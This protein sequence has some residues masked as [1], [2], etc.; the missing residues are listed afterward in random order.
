MADPLNLP[1]GQMTTEFP[2]MSPDFDGRAV[3]L[4][5][6]VEMLEATG[7]GALI[8][9]L[10]DPRLPLIFVNHAFEVI[11]GYSRREAIG[12]NTR[13]LQAADQLQPEIEVLDDAI[14]RRASVSVTLRN[15]RKDGVLFWNALRLLPL[16]D[17]AGRTTH[18][19]GL[20]RDVT[21]SR[22]AAEQLD[23]AGQIDA[24]TGVLNRHAM[25]NQVQKLM[26]DQPGRLMLIKINLASFHEINTGFGH[27]TGDEL[28]RQIAGRLAGLGPEALGRMSGDEFAIVWRLRS[29]ETAQSRLNAIKETLE[30]PYVL[31]GATIEPRFAMGFV[32]ASAGVNAI[33][34]M[35]Q[36]GAALH[37]SR[38]G[39]LREPHEFDADSVARLRNRVRLTG[40]IQHA[41]ANGEFLFHYQP[42][43]DLRS[44]ELVG[45]EALMRWDHGVFGL[46]PPAR[47]IGLAEE[48]GLIVQLGQWGRREAARF[49]AE[50]N[51]GR[52]RALSIAVNIPAAE[53]MHRD[54]TRSLVDALSA[55][56]ADPSWLTLELTET[57]LAEGSPEVLDLLRR[58]KALGVGLSVDDF[59]TGYS[60]LG[61]LDRFPITE[62][63][64][65]RSFIGELRLN[66]GRRIIVKAVI[67]LGR[68]LGID[69][70]AEGIESVADLEILQ[71]I[72][73][74]LGQ[75]FLFSRP[76]PIDEFGAL[77]A[78]AE[79]GV[80][81]LEP[82]EA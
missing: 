48:S 54:F 74:P 57:L 28:I 55:A 9:A 23:R 5:A 34:L 33:T 19:L 73:C 62:V 44:G 60:N 51:R 77:I 3:P 67:D 63:K 81:I 38:S 35:R 13:F 42:K 40:E 39:R 52:E 8:V 30:L 70:V 17:E 78:R 71:S 25:T 29:N 59:G 32:L 22:Q 66:A 64:I 79:A 4:A 36:A 14:A 37:E 76:L 47:F 20:M 15:Y 12:Q 11:M 43:L 24:L 41:L 6:M 27:E 10:D 26:E 16:V 68:E 69:V 80:P 58:V 50:L 72:H 61:Y 1:V 82:R 7:E 21:D 2:P 46:Q 65:D 53:L 31:P 75:G 18:Y 49:A 45:A 56:G